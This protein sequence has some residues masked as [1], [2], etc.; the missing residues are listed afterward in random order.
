MVDDVLS[1]LGGNFP[2]TGEE[3]ASLITTVKP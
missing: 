2:R 3:V 1:V